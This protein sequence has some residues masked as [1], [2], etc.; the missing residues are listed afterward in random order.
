MR[1]FGRSPKTDEATNEALTRTRKSFF[2][3]IGSLFGGGDVTDE[4]WE[5][6]EEVL[7]GADAGVSTTMDVLDRVRA[8]RPRDAE[9]VRAYLR[10]ELVAILDAAAAQPK[11]ALWGDAAETGEGSEPP[12]VVLIVGVNG[13]GKTTAVARLAYAYQQQ[14]QKVIAAAGD[15]FRAAAIDQLRHWGERLDFGVIAHQ[16]GS[17]PAAIVFDAVEA[18]KARGAQLLLIDTAGRLQNKQNLMD[19]LTKIRRVIERHLGRGPDEVALVLD[20]TTGQNG[21]SQARAFIEAVEVTGVILTK[22][23]GTARGGIVFAIASELG[24][25]VRF[26]GTGERPEDLAPFEP[27]PFVDALLATP[28]AAEA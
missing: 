22:L 10:D 24:L 12:A 13:T 25:P 2:G 16:Q 17:D 20:A 11:G 4:L 26:I 23:D 6:L 28:Q 19:E 5:S 7:I 27:G 1:L 9:Q 15:T 3:R 8:R 21:L 14:G 18:A